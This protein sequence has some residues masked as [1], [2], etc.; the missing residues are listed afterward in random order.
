MDFSKWIENLTNAFQKE[1]SEGKR[2]SIQT[3]LQK[4]KQ[5]RDEV[6]L[7]ERAVLVG[8][9]DACLPYHLKSK[10][11]SSE[12]YRSPG[13]NRFKNEMYATSSVDIVKS[14]LRIVKSIV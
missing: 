4:A 14:G 11:F 13:V 8:E 9:A 7:F 12:M 5:A 2:R 1:G 6:N 3:A 10:Q